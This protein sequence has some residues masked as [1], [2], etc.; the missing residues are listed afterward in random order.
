VLAALAAAYRSERVAI[1]GLL[2][3]L[4]TPFLLAGGPVD[5][6]LLAVYLLVLIVG[7]LALSARLRIPRRRR[8]R[9]RRRAVLRPRVLS[10]RELDGLRC[11]RLRV[12]LL[13]DL[14]GCVL[15]A[16]NGRRESIAS[17]ALLIAL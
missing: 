15:A 10:G 1:L 7:M 14:R 4:L 2:G 17:R 6:P 16:A 12:T 13:L 3:G 11:A 8:P 9:I 5:R